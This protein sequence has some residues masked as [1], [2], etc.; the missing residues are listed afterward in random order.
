MACTLVKDVTLPED[1]PPR[2]GGFALIRWAVINSFLVTLA[3]RLNHR[4]LPDCLRDLAN[5]V[6]EVFAWLT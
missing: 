4:I 1:D 2:R 5:Q 3:R 6:E